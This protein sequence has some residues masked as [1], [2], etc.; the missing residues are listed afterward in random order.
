MKNLICTSMIS[1]LFAAG[2]LTIAPVQA[3]D[4]ATSQ[5][6]ENRMLSDFLDIVKIRSQTKNERKIADFLKARLVQLGGEVSED[7]AYKAFGGNTGNIFAYFKGNISGAPVMLLNA[8]I[9]TVEPSEDVVPHIVDGVIRPTGKTILGA[10]DKSGVISILEALTTIKEKK[11]SHADVLVV[12]TVAEESGMLG[13]KNINQ[14]MLHKADFGISMDGSSETGG[15]FFNAPGANIMKIAVEGK[16]A[17]AGQG[18]R[19]RHQCHH[20]CQQ[21]YRHPQARP[22]R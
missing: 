16:A 22:S 4:P 3:A 21:G 15:I 14:S 9:D 7:E 13:A 10:D 2:V 18:S 17:H 6:N 20:P 19:K 11:I 5:I 8:H 12:F 1:A